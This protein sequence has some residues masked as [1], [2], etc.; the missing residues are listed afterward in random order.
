MEDDLHESA[1]ASAD[2]PKVV[3]RL[4]RRTSGL[5]GANV[6]LPMLCALTDLVLMLTSLLA[7]ARMRTSLPFLDGANDV[8]AL[9]TALGGFIVAGWL[10]GLWA[11]GSYA[12]H[13]LSAGL[14]EYKKVINGSVVT[15]G[16]VGIVCYLAKIPL[17]RGFFAMA[18]L[19]G[20]PL[21]LLGRFLLRRALHRWRMRGLFLQRVVW[22]AN[23]D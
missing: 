9:V 11:V 17:S 3:H 14:E 10:L 6:V 22:V 5:I 13:L 12:P 23:C 21:L 8:H 18:F 19:I 2:A 20:I 7:A 15:A 4:V 16:G 1:P